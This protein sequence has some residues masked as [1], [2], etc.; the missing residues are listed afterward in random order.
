MGE[1]AHP[2]VP[3]PLALLSCTSVTS[4]HINVPTSQIR[5][6]PLD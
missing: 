3:T 6:H 1:N 2:V 4:S 5:T